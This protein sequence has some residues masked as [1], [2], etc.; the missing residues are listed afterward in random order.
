M[1]LVSQ[2]V[3]AAS[4]I[5]GPRF[6]HSLYLR[7]LERWGTYEPEYYLLDHLVDPSRASVDVGANEGIYSG[8]MAQLCP[9]VHC[10][11]PIPWFAA[12]LRQKLP[13]S[14]IIHECALSNRAGTGELRIPYHDQTEMHGTS[15]L[16]TDNPLPG[17]T[18]IK[19]VTCR[20]ARLDDII[21]EPVGFVKID[22]EGHELAVLEG[23][24]QILREHRPVLLIESEK[25]HNHTAPESIF[26]FLAARGYTGFFQ[27]R[28]RLFGISAF[29]AE[30]DQSPVNVT[31]N[32][33][34]KTSPYINNFIFVPGT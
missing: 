30:L 28:A 32:V 17:S 16:E 14:V 22:V 2:I 20:L 33:K 21:D 27:R 23:A 4:R 9:R 25:R 29:R 12:A 3:D 19:Q 10:F 26:T 8:R 34:S 1:I 31:G 18:H 13:A 15:T 24:E 5:G 6:A 7:R 11:E